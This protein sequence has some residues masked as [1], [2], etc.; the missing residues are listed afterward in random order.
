M[1]K[2]FLLYILG[3]YLFTNRGQTVSLRWLSHFRDFKGA[4]EANWGQACLAYLYSSLDTLNRRTFCQ[5]VGPWKLLDVSLFSF[6]VSYKCTPCLCK[7]CSSTHHLGLKKLYLMFLQTIFMPLSC[8]LSSYKLHSYLYLVNCTYSSCK[9]S[10][11]KLHLFILQNVIV[12]TVFI[13][14]ANCHLVNYT[15][16]SCKLSSCKLCSFFSALGYEVQT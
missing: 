14:L 9:L 13:H 11:C 6:V 3:A 2:A 5:L 10:S 16:S 1:A 15:H 4:L 8:K 7:L 12:Q